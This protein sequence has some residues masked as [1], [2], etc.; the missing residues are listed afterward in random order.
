MNYRWMTAL[1]VALGAG[2]IAAVVLPRLTGSEGTNW[3]ATAAVALVAAL[4]F[5]AATRE[6]TKEDE[7]HG[8]T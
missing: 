7:T 4:V 1:F 2:A 3:I 5:L 8:P 6:R